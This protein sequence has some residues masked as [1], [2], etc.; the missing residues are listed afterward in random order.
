M[1]NPTISD[2]NTKEEI[3]DGDIKNTI[4]WVG[5]MVCIVLVIFFLCDY[6]FKTRTMYAEQG[7]EQVAI[8]GSDYPV[9]QKVR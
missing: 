9:W 5:A 7:Y 3:M 8:V 4:Y 1:G 6:S 2:K